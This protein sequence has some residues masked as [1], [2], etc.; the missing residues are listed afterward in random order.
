MLLGVPSIQNLLHALPQIAGDQRLVLA[1][2]ETAIPLKFAHVETITQHGMD[3]AHWHR[4]SALTVDES[5]RLRP[6]GCFLQRQG[7]SRVPLEQTRNDRRGLRIG[8]DDF[9]AIWSSDIAIAKG[10]DR[11]PNALLGLLLHS[12][13]RFLR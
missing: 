3:R 13:T 6:L 11:R 5:G 4:R 12:F 1:Q 7:A 8:L 2:I 9:L 10:R